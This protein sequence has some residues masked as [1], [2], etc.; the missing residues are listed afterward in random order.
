MKRKILISAI[1]SCLIIGVMIWF[2]LFDIADNVSGWLQKRQ[3][4][5][6]WSLNNALWTLGVGLIPLMGYLTLLTTDKYTWANFLIQ[7]INV[8]LGMLFVFFV[9]YLV[10]RQLSTPPSVLLPDYVTYEPFTGYWNFALY[11]GLI[12]YVGVFVG[13]QRIKMKNTEHNKA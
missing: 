5:I 10:A 2:G 11:V 6:A 9:A 4:I 13:W 7:T 8:F 1:V 3:I 12:F